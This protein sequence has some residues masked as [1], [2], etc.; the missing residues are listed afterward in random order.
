[1]ISHRGHYFVICGDG[2][3]TEQLIESVLDVLQ[4]ILVAVG[5]TVDNDI[6][7]FTHF[8]APLGYV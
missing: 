3:I 4:M 8:P 5:V 6:V 1:M 2:Y 7:P